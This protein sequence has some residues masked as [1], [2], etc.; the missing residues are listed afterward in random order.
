MTKHD[1]M[2]RITHQIGDQNFYNRKCCFLFKKI[3][4]YFFYFF[5]HKYFKNIKKN[6]IKNTNLKPFHIQHSFQTYLNIIKKKQTNGLETQ[7]LMI[8]VLKLDEQ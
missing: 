7:Q 8:I 5:R 4:K 6:S 2:E 3:S 1:I